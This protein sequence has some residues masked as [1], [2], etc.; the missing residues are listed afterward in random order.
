MSTSSRGKSKPTARSLPRLLDATGEIVWVLDAEHRIVWINDACGAW[1]S[2]DASTL[3]GRVAAASSGVDDPLDFVAANLAPPLGLSEAGLLCNVCEPLNAAPRLIRFLRIGSDDSAII[4]ASS[5]D[6]IAMKSDADAVDVAR[7]QTRIHQWRKRD[8]AWG[9]IVA[10]GS[11]RASKRLRAQIQL[12]TSTRQDISVVGPTGCGSEVIARRIHAG[13]KIG[14]NGPRAISEPLI[15][16]DG[17]LMDAELLE[18]SLSPAASHLGGDSE[19]TEPP[20]VTLVLRGLDETPLDVQQRIEQFISEHGS[21]VRLMGLLRNSVDETSQE[22]TLI[23]HLAMRLDVLSIRID[24]FAS[25]AEDV[26]LIASAIVDSRHATGQ[27]SAERLNRAALDRL[28]LYPWPGNFEE[29]DAA[30]RHALSVCHGSA[31]GPEHLPLAIRSY[32]PGEPKRQDEL[33][34]SDLD[35]AMERY[36][37]KLIQAAVDASGGNRSEAARKLSISRA[38]LLRRLGDAEAGIPSDTE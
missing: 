4:M 9:G 14:N 21:S 2:V 22:G 12:A 18:A 24:A 5:G 27:G 16:I 32:Q 31:I 28:M 20:M 3:I 7:L 8:S 13:F 34:V 15:A 11:S 23:A 29:L 6:P 1:L 36:E 17:P 10:A 19:R 30:M 35:K 37:L 25:R 33:L 38:R 26:P